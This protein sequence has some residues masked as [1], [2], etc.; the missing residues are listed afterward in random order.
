MYKLNSKNVRFIY[1]VRKANGRPC[2][3][4]GK[5]DSPCSPV[6]D[7]RSADV[8]TPEVWFWIE[9]WMLIMKHPLSDCSLQ[10]MCYV[11]YIAL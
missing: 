9:L 7:L 1:L 5:V 3:G 4:L 11:L 8:C 6:G 2:F 10:F